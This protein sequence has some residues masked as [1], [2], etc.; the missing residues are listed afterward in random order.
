MFNLLIS[1]Y[2]F[3][4]AAM[5]M[6]VIAAALS[7]LPNTALPAT[8]TFAP[9]STTSGAVPSSMPPSTSSSQAGRY[10]FM[11]ALMPR[12]LGSM[13]AMK[14]CPPKPGSTVMTNTMSS[15]SR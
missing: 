12:I 8:S 10:S 5:R 14:L 13:S 6:P 4:S 11:S 1:D 2:G 15:L 7:G 3:T 9:A